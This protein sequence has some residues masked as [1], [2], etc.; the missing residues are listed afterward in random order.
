MPIRTGKGS[1]QSAEC[2]FF[3]CLI[4]HRWSFGW[5]REVC[6][7]TVSV[8]CSAH[9][10]KLR[11]W[12]RHSSLGSL[13]GLHVSDC[14]IA[15]VQL[16]RFWRKERSLPKFRFCYLDTL[17]VALLCT[18]RNMPI[19]YKQTTSW[20]WGKM[21]LSPLSV[22]LRPFD[23]RMVDGPLNRCQWKALPQ[24][25]P[26]TSIMQVHSAMY[27]VYHFRVQSRDNILFQVIDY[28]IILARPPSERD[29]PSPWWNCGWFSP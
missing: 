20:A 15:S 14:S 27:S 11:H 4:L 29:S 13:E 23:W 17:E 6:W 3:T 24:N 19:L 22:R 8:R 10:Y 21:W 5:S 2:F 25:P 26:L 7:R 12:E 16:D 18:I 9:L 1:K 28:S